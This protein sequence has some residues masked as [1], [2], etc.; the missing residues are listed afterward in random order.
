MALPGASRL[1]KALAQVEVDATDASV[2]KAAGELVAAG[3]RPKSPSSRVARTGRVAV[4]RGV[5]RVRFGGPATPWAGP[6][7]FGHGTPSSPR[8]QGGYMVAD[9]FLYD[10]ADA[11]RE[12][13]TDLY[14]TRCVKAIRDNGL[15]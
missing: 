12:Q 5:A 15:S 9:P 8:P 14:L 3:A 6:G 7:H 11:R 13:V 4:A 1:D 2:A 10:E